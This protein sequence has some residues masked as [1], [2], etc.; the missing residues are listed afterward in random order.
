MFEYN[1]SRTIDAYLLNAGNLKPSSYEYF[2]KTVYNNKNYTQKG[3][4][5]VKALLQE[6][7]ITTAN[8][9]ILFNLANSSNGKVFYPNE[10]EELKNEIL[11]L[12]N[13][14]TLAYTESNTK[15]IIHNKWLFFVIIVL[16]SAEWF[17]RKYLGGY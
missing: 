17:Y 8:H 14:N 6:F 7:S 5:E 15:N 3:L 2:A 10:W 1:F 11:N 9:N 4:F 13:I 12:P 16:L